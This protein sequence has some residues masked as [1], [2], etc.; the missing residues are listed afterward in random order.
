MPG[1]LTFNRVLPAFPNVWPYNTERFDNAELSVKL[2]MS[3]KLVVSAKKSLFFVMANDPRDGENIVAWKVH[4]SNVEK[5]LRL[6][7][8]AQS[9]V[10]TDMYAS[11]N[12]LNGH[13]D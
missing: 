1:L 12:H 2:Q 11:S 13:S 8:E 10:Q 4:V 3:Q 5:H 7:K 6:H 9:L